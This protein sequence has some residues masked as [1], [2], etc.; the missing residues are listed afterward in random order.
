MSIFGVAVEEKLYIPTKTGRRG[1]GL[2]PVIMNSGTTLGVR[3][4]YRP[5]TKKQHDNKLKH[6]MDKDSIINILSS[7]HHDKVQSSHNV[8]ISY[9]PFRYT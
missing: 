1:T 2:V 7:A 4:R 6:I 5:L 9:Q 8:Q 3:T